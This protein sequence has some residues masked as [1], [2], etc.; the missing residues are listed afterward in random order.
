MAR[1][2]TRASSHYLEVAIPAV[3]AYPW[4]LSA[5]FRSDDLTTNQTILSIGDTLTN[6]EYWS[7][8]AT[9]AAAGDPVRM[10]SSTTVGGAFTADTT[11]GYAANTW[12]H[13][14][15]TGASA[16]ARTVYIDGGSSATNTS[17]ST[18]AG[19]DNTDLGRLVRL[20]PANYFSG[21]IA[22]AAVW[23][24][25]LTASEIAAL[26]S[27]VSPHRIRPTALQLYVPV[28]GV[29][30]PE[31]DYSGN[32]RHMTISGPTVADHPPLQP[33][34]AFHAGSQ[35][36]LRALRIPVAVHSYRQ[37]RALV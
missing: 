24:A 17:S 3:T 12:H 1:V 23:N 32:A 11:T 10:T 22:E 26:A 16:T 31:P 35:G 4:T 2:F 25:V 5:W 21:R 19:L 14:L 34:W 6:T 28:Y 36:N 30:S 18:P 7:L 27:R 13:A 29:G 9:G 15:A 20:T 8:Q 37:R 33:A